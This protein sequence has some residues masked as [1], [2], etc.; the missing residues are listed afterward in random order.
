M[1][2]AL[3]RGMVLLIVIHGAALAAPSVLK[4]NTPAWLEHSG[5]RTTL[6]PGM[7]IPAGA[8]VYSGENGALTVEL[9]P[10]ARVRLG[11]DSVLRFT[12]ADTASPV[13]LELVQGTAR[14]TAN[15][16][17]PGNDTDLPIRLGTLEL[18]LKAGDILGRKT[19]K[20][21]LAMLIEG[22][23]GVTHEAV[24]TQILRRPM[25]Y[26]EARADSVPSPVL[27]ANPP[28][29]A[30]W[31]KPFETPLPDTQP[32]AKRGAWAVQLASL[33]PD[34]PLEPFTRKLQIKGIPVEIVPATVSGRDFKR[35]RVS[36][37]ETRAEAQ[38]F[39]QRMSAEFG[40]ENP[41]VTCLPSPEACR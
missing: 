1:R 24:G 10:T 12:Q 19:E 6:R 14:F 37:F 28:W 31:L 15:P 29:A 4:L 7:D 11:T 21:A 41:W 26:I 36:G 25:S 17:K 3:A 39:A 40:I 23:L 20:H 27:P 30:A 9:S 34:A 16:G 2:R 22:E 38:A 8:T 32:S 18:N 33:A 13:A 35:V 5:Q